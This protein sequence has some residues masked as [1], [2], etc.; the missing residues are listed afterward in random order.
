MSIAHAP[1][2]PCWF[3]LITSDLPA[4]IDYYTGLFGWQV[5][6]VPMDDGSEYAIF[7][8]D[9]R[10]VAAAAQMDA[11]QAAQGQPAYW[12]A[13]F[14]VDDVDAAAEA[15]ARSGGQVLVPPFEVMGH[16]RMAVCADP[17]G[18]AFSLMQPRAH[19]GVGAIREQNAVCWVE[20]AARDIVAAESFYAGLLGWE[21]HDHTASP[22]AGYRIY[23]NGDGQLGGLLRMTEEWGE[24][25]AH[26]SL[27]MQVAD[28]DASVARAQA[29]GG[30]LCFPAFDAPGVGR[31]ARVDGPD[32]AGLY[33]ITFAAQG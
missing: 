26:W 3:E 22:A 20:L 10:E 13:Y 17:E 16:L 8:I 19:P 6:R 25:P 27:Y 1:G 7:S 28:V 9:G 11:E 14:R 32:G 23:A 30:R 2:S 15:V 12:G 4:A 21:M 29:L 24:M 5:A 33:F 18:A 31:I